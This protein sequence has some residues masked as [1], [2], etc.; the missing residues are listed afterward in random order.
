MEIG[1]VIARKTVNVS[2]V[3][4]MTQFGFTLSELL[5]AGAAR[6]KVGG[7]IRYTE[8]G[9]VPTTTDGDPIVADGAEW[10]FGHQNTRN[11]QVV[12][13]SGTVSVSIALHKDAKV[14]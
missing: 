1:P 8:D 2:T 11:L 5:L 9:S 14:A 6:V 7:A 12:S 4:T 10:I 3:V 13:Q